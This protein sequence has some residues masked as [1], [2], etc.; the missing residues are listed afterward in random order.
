MSALLYPYTLA[1]LPLKENW[2]VVALCPIR[3]AEFQLPIVNA[4]TEDAAS[5]TP[6][7]Y[8]DVTLLLTIPVIWY[9]VFACIVVVPVVK[10]LFTSDA[11]VA[12][13]WALLFDIESQLSY[14]F[15][16]GPYITWFEPV[17]TE[18]FTKAHIVKG[19]VKFG[20]V[21]TST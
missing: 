20:V 1:I 5:N 7:M 2:P 12:S 13:I 10:K 14:P 17:I 11:C 9:Q 21:V 3:A 16:D 6:F 4:C 19:F 8:S 18:V 15:A